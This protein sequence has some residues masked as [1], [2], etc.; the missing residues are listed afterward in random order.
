MAVEA[1]FTSRPKTEEMGE[2]YQMFPA[3]FVRNNL[4][5]LFFL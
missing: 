5:S 1:I 4:I 2:M 3:N